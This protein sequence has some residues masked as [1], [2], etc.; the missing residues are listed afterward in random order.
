MSDYRMPDG[1]HTTSQKRYLSAWGKLNDAVE[2]ALGARVYA[3]DPNVAVC[4]PD[5]RGSCTLPMWV[6]QKV[7]ALQAP[8]PEPS[9]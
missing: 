6:A 8:P 3:F 5:G 1:T 4:L 9:P 7:A 2:R